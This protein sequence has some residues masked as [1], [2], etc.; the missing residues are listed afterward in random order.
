VKGGPVELSPVNRVVVFILG[1]AFLTI[2]LG[3]LVGFLK[4]S[5]YGYWRTR[6]GITAEARLVFVEWRYHS[7]GRGG[8]S[9]STEVSY[10]YPVGDKWFTGSRITLF[11]TTER[12]YRPLR[13][14]MDEGRPIR[15]FIDPA[16]PQFSVIDR[17]F[18]LF[19]LVIAVPFSLAFASAGFFLEW[20]L[21]MNL[22]GK[23]IP[24]K[25]PYVPVRKT[26]RAE[27]R[28][29]AAARRQKG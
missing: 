6:A 25:P 27:R 14:A 5:V 15:V 23:A 28:R 26:S 21:W 12:Y 3:L 22:Q 20:C 18:A 7:G 4:D 24:S 11:K 29:A 9:S 1:A 16:H 10:G 19:P 2:G 17:D 8:G 13:R